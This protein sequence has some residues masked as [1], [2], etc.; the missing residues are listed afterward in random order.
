V[1]RAL[2]AHERSERIAGMITD[3]VMIVGTAALFVALYCLL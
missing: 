3:I 2:A 1:G